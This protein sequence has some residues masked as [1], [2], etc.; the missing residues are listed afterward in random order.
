MSAYNWNWGVLF[1]QPYVGWLL[2]GLGVTVVLA[3]S[4]WVIALALGSL[5]GVARTLPFAPLRWLATAYVELFRNIPVLVQMFLWFFVLPE[6]VP[7]SFG[8]WLKRDLPHPEFFSAMVC[9]GLYTASRVAEQ[10]RSGINS[11]PQG[12]SAAARASGLSVAQTYRHVL[13][14]IGFRIIV[15]PLTSEFL[16]IFKNTSIALTIGVMEITATSRQIE[17]YTFQGYEAFAAA[18]VLYLS[19]AATLLFLMRRLEARTRIPG[20]IA[21]GND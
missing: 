7:E 8:Y 14:P 5:I 10:V 4:A 6:L 11:V 21:R 19:I 9:L 18:T 16:G 20:W 17:S 13:L 15:P 12:L 1:S 2:M 3:L